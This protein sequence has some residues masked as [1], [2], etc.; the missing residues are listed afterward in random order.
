MLRTI[1]LRKRAPCLS[2]STTC[3]FLCTGNSAR[4]IIAEAILNR[5]GAGKFRGHSA[6]S[7]PR[8]RSTRN[9]LQLLAR[10]GFETAGFRAK[11]WSEFARPDAPA[12]D[13]IVTVCDDAAGETCPV[14]PGRPM[15]AH[16][17]SPIR[18]RR[19]ARRPKSRWHSAMPAG[20]C[21]PDRG[22]RGAAD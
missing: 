22:V 12:L 17:A 3:L 6:G 18:R 8:E 4:S 21:T 1:L 15:T 14:W 13:F 7:H 10:L 19:P 20:C 16:W 9:T 5:I 2:G 11:S